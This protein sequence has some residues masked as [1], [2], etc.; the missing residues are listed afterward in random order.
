MLQYLLIRQ[1][2]VAVFKI[3]DAAILKSSFKERAL[4]RQIVAVGINAQ[5]VTTRKTLIYTIADNALSLLCHRNAM[6]HAIRCII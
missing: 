4:H 2:F 6:N 1:S 5:I 3:D